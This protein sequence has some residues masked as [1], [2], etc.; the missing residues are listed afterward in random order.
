MKN[1]SINPSFPGQQIKTVTVYI[2]RSE[3]EAFTQL[4]LPL[5]DE[6]DEPAINST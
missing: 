4:C 1:P 2:K 3:H 6:D 5:F